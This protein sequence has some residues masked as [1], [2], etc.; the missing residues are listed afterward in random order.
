MC[1]ACGHHLVTQNISQMCLK[2]GSLLISCDTSDRDDDDQMS[3]DCH[4][5]NNK[6]VRD[7]APQRATCDKSFAH[8]ERLLSGIKH[9]DVMGNAALAE[10]LRAIDLTLKS[11]LC[12]NTLCDCNCEKCLAG[13]CE[14]CS[15]PECVDPNCEGSVK[16]RQTAEELALLKSF[17][18][19]VKFIVQPP[20]RYR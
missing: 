12:E 1:Q 16:A 18:T 3:E 5:S 7:W 6:H 9:G 14:D 11:L 20:A 19:E 10:Q 2:C 8:V 13:D 15:D 4:D 17:A